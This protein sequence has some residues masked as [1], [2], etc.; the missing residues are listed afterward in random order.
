MSSLLSARNPLNRQDSRH[1][2]GIGGDDGDGHRQSG[3]GQTD[4]AEVKGQAD[5]DNK[6]QDQGQ[7]G[8][9]LTQGRR[10]MAAIEDHWSDIGVSLRAEIND[11]TA[12][13]DRFGPVV[14]FSNDQILV[15]KVDY[16]PDHSGFSR[17]EIGI[18]EIPVGDPPG[19]GPKALH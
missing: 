8:Q 4:P 6:G 17:A 13:E 1:H 2:P 16:F 18:I 9:A 11:L 15:A 3:R 7:R 19:T 12:I 14:V 5:T 10:E